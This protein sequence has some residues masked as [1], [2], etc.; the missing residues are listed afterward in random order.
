[1]S[2]PPR[3]DIDIHTLREPAISVVNASRFA[4]CALALSEA[5]D[6]CC[7]GMPVDL[8]EIACSAVE[9]VRHTAPALEARP[10][11]RLHALPWVLGAPELLRQ[12]FV[13]LVANAFRFTRGVPGPMVEIGLSA[14][15]AGT[16]L[17]VR[18]NGIGFEASRADALCQPFGFG[19][20]L[21]RRVV[22]RHG[23]HVWA[24][25]G[26]AGATFYFTLSGLGEPPAA[27]T[28]RGAHP[29]L[30]APPAASTPAPA[31]CRTAPAPAA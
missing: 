1:M 31:A 11:V 21:V 30:P 17:Y 20:G 6:A 8:A 23:G 18:D 27:A 26:A 3:A 12:V 4:Q 29:L 9:Q 22:E 10:E 25:A 2:T 15:A 13:T 16:A 14:C 19:L 7:P 5:D 28:A 24:D